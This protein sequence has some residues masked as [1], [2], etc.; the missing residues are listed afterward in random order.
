MI[1]SPYTLMKCIFIPVSRNLSWHPA[2][3][4]QSKMYIP[5]SHAFIDLNN[6][7]TAGKS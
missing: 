3:E 6:D 2:L 7:F 4:T 5:H 1:N